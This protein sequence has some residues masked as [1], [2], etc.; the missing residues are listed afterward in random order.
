MN[1]TNASA[2]QGSAA[3]PRTGASGT[4]ASKA[5]ASKGKPKSAAKGGK[6]GGKGGG[7]KRTDRSDQPRWKFWLRR[8]G[9]GALIAGLAVALIGLIALIIKYVSLEVPEPDDFAQAQA[10]TFYYADGETE[11]GSLGVANREVV[12]IETLPDHVGNAVV[13]AEDRSFWT[14]PGIDVVGMSRALFRTVVMNE[15][16]G[17]SSITQQYVERYYVGETTT[18][19]PG[20]IEETLLALKIDQEQSKEEVLGNYL[21]TIYFGRGAYGIQAAAEQYYGKPAADLT[22]SESAML[23]GIIPAPSNWD[24]R[25]DPE[26]AEQRWN[27]VLDGM[28][29]AEFLTQDE[30]DD[31]T[32][33][34]EPIEYQNADVFAGTQGYILREAMDE[35]VERTGASQEEIESLG[36]RV[37]TT[38]VP[39]HQQAA[40]DAVAQMPDDHADN[41]R[42]AAVTM[43]AATGAVTSMYGGPDYLEV[44]RNAVTQDVAQAGSTFKP[45]AL[46]GALERG[47]S[48]ETEYLSNN[49][50][51]F[52]GFDRPVRNFG[53]VD[54]GYIDL[55]RATQSSVNTAYVQLGLE[56]TPQVVMET[57]IKAGLPEDTLGLEPNAS[58]VLGTASPHAL[59]MAHA[60]ATIA[61]AG[62]RTEPFMVQTV[63]DSDGEVVYEH[64]VEDERVFAEDVMADT[65]YAM[66]QV[67]RFGSGEFANQIGRPLAGKTG[68][69]NENRSA[70]FVGFSPQIVGSVSLYQVGEDGSAEQ[71]TPFGG[72]DQITGST[73]PSRVWTWMM[74]PI[75]EPMEVV[76]FPP[77]ANVGEVA[78]SEPPPPEP[79]PTP[80]ETVSRPPEPE[81]EPEPEEPEPEPEPE[82]PEPE[83]EDPEPSPEPE[84]SGPPTADPDEE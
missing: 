3:K 9:F 57:A 66:Q 74:E 31:I 67:V 70:W 71:I 28:V 26:R 35:V 83:P 15:Q 29:D 49:E 27:Y 50:M 51:E 33:F 63:T 43:D 64:E 41:L 75:L 53:G 80:S 22:L 1:T 7:G 40:E 59:D 12:G 14:N 47:I 46:I 21:N 38:I 84:P 48:L 77:R 54:Y 17:G 18:S 76:D 24:P 34:P 72:F 44:Q 42:V 39:E 78:N 62:V 69:S 6:G 65:T 56:V 68:T 10:S 8:I 52:E 5:G 73:V 32:Q 2:R 16:Q 81:P 82:E 4:A 30:R 36:Y 58:N 61:N 11:L 60:Y 79:S 23:A 37:T 55:V 20:K 19:I 45:F 25:I 13:A